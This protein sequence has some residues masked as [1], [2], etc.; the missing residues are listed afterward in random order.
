MQEAMVMSD[1]S[2]QFD[3][4]SAQASAFLVCEAIGIQGRADMPGNLYFFAAPDY[5]SKIP[6]EQEKARQDLEKFGSVLRIV[7]QKDDPNLF[8]EF[9]NRLLTT[10]QATFSSGRFR[11]EPLNDLATFRQEIVQLAG[12]RIK[13]RYTKRLLCA[14]VYASLFLILCSSVLQIVMNFGM[15]RAND[16]WILLHWNQNVSIFHTGLLLTAAMWGLLFASVARNI[17]PT[18]EALLTPDADL[19]PP[20]GRLLFY[21]IAVLILALLFELR[22]VTLNLGEGFSTASISE[23]GATA[24]FIGLL[25]GVLERALPKEVEKWSKEMLPSVGRTG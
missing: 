20:W 10:A 5:A 13:E 19:M 22:V 18:F 2:S 16:Q 12:G 17:E 21:G 1:E 25:L 24:L 14:V 6:S 7:F 11:P 15:S 9:F 3:G 23:D 4:D 8:A